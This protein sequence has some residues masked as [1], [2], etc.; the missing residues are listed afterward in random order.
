MPAALTSLMRGWNVE[1]CEVRGL[2]CSGR[3]SKPSAWSSVWH[4]VGPAQHLLN[5]RMMILGLYG[6][7][8]AGSSKYSVS[9]ESEAALPSGLQPSRVLRGSWGI[10]SGECSPGV[11]VLHGSGR[12]PGFL[13]TDMRLPWCFSEACLPGSACFHLPGTSPLP[14]LWATPR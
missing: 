6:S 3:C 9:L 4:I 12:C 11:S 7:L 1:L 8:A 5:Q 2:V 10:C 13:S 14:P